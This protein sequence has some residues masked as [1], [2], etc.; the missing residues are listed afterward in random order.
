MR[1]RLLGGP[2]CRAAPV[3]QSCG[4]LSQGGWEC[5]AGPGG[6]GSPAHLLPQSAEGLAGGPQPVMCVQSAEAISPE[7]LPLPEAAQLGESSWSSRPLSLSRTFCL[8]FAG[9]QYPSSSLFAD[10]QE[11]VI[12]IP[13]LCERIRTSQ[14]RLEVRGQVPHPVHPM[15]SKQS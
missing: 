5:R 13:L 7:P 9:F 3:H 2:P 12:S 11:E 14:I 6:P 1:V 10:I 4:P 8:F 15:P